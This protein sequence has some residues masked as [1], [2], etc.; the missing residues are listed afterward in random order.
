MIK[1][2]ILLDKNINKSFFL[3]GPRQSGKSTLLHHFFKDSI[4]IDLLNSEE[5]V[6]YTHHPERLKE[7]LCT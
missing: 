1:R 7:E 2:L 6:K 3:W 4:W 5:F